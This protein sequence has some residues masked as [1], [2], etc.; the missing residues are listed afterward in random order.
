MLVGQTVLF[1]MTKVVGLELGVH[2]PDGDVPVLDELPPHAAAS[3]IAL[4]MIVPPTNILNV[5][6]VL[7]YDSSRYFAR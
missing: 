3:A 6:I 1:M 5:C 2:V 4:A 7:P